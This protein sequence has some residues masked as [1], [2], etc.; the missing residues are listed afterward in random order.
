LGRITC[1]DAKRRERRERDQLPFQQK[2]IGCIRKDEA[3]AQ[4]VVVNVLSGVSRLPLQHNNPFVR[5]VR[6]KT[7]AQTAQHMSTTHTCTRI[8]HR[9]LLVKNTTPHT[10]THTRAHR[11]KRTNHTHTC[12]QMQTH[13][14]HMCAQKQTQKF[15]RYDA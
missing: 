4:C 15:R 10:H 6:I 7:N 14:S 13:K 5:H 1:L 8:R 12:A 2:N 3:S 9:C 11:C